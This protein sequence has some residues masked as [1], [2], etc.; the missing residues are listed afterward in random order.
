MMTVDEYK[1][2][3]AYKPIY[4]LRGLDFDDLYI[5]YYFGKGFTLSEISKIIGLTMPCVTARKHKVQRNT[6]I[7]L[8]EYN[9]QKVAMTDEGKELCALATK[10]IEVFTDVWRSQLVEVP[11]TKPIDQKSPRNIKNNQGYLAGDI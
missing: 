2:K 5:M 11:R 7:L 4:Q 9:K 1:N 8:W 6:G 10:A 3:V